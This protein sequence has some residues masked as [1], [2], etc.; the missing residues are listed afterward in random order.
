MIYITGDTH[1]NWISRLN[2]RSLPDQKN[3][4]KND[5]V[6]VLGDFGIWDDSKAQKH[7]LDWLEEK[8]FTTLFL[9]GNHENYDILDN[10]PVEPFAGDLVQKIRPS[11]IHLMRRQIYKLESEQPI[12]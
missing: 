10:I 2:T 7:N 6:I 1:T 12:I 5:Y 9:D 8:P 11:I 3:I 4:T